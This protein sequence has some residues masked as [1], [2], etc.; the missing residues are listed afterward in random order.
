MRGGPGND[1]MY[2]ECG[3]D[4]VYG[5]PGQDSL[6]DYTRAKTYLYGGADDDTFDATRNEAGNNAF[7]PDRVSGDTGHD[8]ALCPLR[9]HCD[10][11]NRGMT[12]P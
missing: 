8:M 2:S 3:V 7:I 6:I 5:G 1:L 4:R 11:V 9:R 10:V 12:F